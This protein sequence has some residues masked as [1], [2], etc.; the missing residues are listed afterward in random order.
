MIVLIPSFLIEAVK[1]TAPCGTLSMSNVADRGTSR[2]DARGL[3]PTLGLVL[4]HEQP[5]MSRAASSAS[6]VSLLENVILGKGCTL[7]RFGRDANI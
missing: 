4:C 7:L 3:K 5:A 1:L 2:M 6:Q